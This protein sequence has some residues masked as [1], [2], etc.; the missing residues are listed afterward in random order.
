MERTT[1]ILSYPYLCLA[2]QASKHK[3]S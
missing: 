3:L 1:Y 2:M